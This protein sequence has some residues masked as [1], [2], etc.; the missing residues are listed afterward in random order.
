VHAVATVNAGA[1]T[2]RVFFKR[3]RIKRLHRD[4]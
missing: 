2:V 4:T 3:K 1:R